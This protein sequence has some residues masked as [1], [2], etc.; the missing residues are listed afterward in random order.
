VAERWPENKRNS[1]QLASYAVI[2]LR[3][4]VWTQNDIKNDI[5]RVK[6]PGDEFVLET[7]NRR[8]RPRERRTLLTFS[9]RNDLFVASGGWRVQ[10]ERPTILCCVL[11]TEHRSIISR[12]RKRKTW[13]CY[14]Q[15]WFFTVLRKRHRNNFEG[16]CF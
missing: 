10:F 12:T 5:A 3:H 1:R 16:L 13:Y 11:A 8:R 14:L 15:K 6:R 7:R 4:Y 2:T 9:A